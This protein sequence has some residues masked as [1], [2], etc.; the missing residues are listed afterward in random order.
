VSI[1]FALSLDSTRGANGGYFGLQLGG[2][3]STTNQIAYIVQHLD[4]DILEY[5]FQPYIRKNE[6]KNYGGVVQFDN[7]F[8]EA[9]TQHQSLY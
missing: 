1:R 5:I 3:V 4:G 8:S 2:V 9:S 7:I 6:K